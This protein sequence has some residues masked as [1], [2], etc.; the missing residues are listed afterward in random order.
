MQALGEEQIRLFSNKKH[1]KKEG[2][3]WKYAGSI[4]AL[5]YRRWG[6]DVPIPGSSRVWTKSHEYGEDFT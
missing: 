1:G 6:V 5:P 3:Y 4:A 2:I